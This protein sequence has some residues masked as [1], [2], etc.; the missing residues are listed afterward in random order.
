MTQD[1]NALIAWLIGTGRQLGDPVQIVE[2]YCTRLRALGVPLS[3]VRV[4]QSYANPLLSAWG[5]VWTP[6]K[7]QRYNVPVDVLATAAWKGSPFEHVVTTRTPLRKRLLQPG[8]T[9]EHP[10]YGELAAAGATDFLALPLEYGDGTVQGSSFTTDMPDGFTE[11]QLGILTDSR[12]ALAAALEPV[13]MRES[14]KSLLRTYLG[15]GPAR[16]VGQGHIKRGETRS[17]QAAILFAD[18]RGYTSRTDQLAETRVL[19]LLGRFFDLIVTSVQDQGGDILKFMGDG[20]LAMFGA[21]PDPGQACTAALRACANA[22]SAMESASQDPGDE[23]LLPFVIGIDFGQVTFGNIGSPDRLDFTVVGSTVN[24]ASRVQ[25][26]CKDLK[27]KALVT[28]AVADHAPEF[29]LQPIGAHDLRGLHQP[30]ELF[31][32]DT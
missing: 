22:L 8:L 27:E 24:R 2:G 23:A 15:D 18:L 26:V 25:S 31:R 6:E 13:A 17:M 4:G 32:F 11:E 20:V 9:Q 7:T 28:A 10:V 3:R 5:I 21:D 12:N 29:G 16:E 1:T 14:Q 30:V 19:T